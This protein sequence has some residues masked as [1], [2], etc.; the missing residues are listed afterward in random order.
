[1]GS[2]VAPSDDDGA[3]IARQRFVVEQYQSLPG[4]SVERLQ[5]GAQRPRKQYAPDGQSRS[6]SQVVVVM[7]TVSQRPRS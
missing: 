1:L 3:G 2:N 6:T 4:Q 5:R 7:S